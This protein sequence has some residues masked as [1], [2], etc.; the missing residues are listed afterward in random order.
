MFVL[1]RHTR[2]F[3]NPNTNETKRYK[4]S[5]DTIHTVVAQKV[6]LSEQFVIIGLKYNDTELNKVRSN[7]ALGHKS[8][9]TVLISGNQ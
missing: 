9:H 2:H 6:I 4:S 7:D 5:Q 1:R 3:E 8:K